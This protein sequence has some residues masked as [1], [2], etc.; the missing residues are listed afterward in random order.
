M[1]TPWPALKSA[2]PH[3]PVWHHLRLEERQLQGR[4]GCAQSGLPRPTAS[5]TR[6]ALREE[7][8]LRRNPYFMRMLVDVI[9][10]MLVLPKEV[11]R[12]GGGAMTMDDR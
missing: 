3:E 5:E 9:S 12:T 6:A 11:L 8:A 1:G 2:G 4:T 7:P 10:A